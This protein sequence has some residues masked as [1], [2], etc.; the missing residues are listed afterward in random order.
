M[1]RIIGSSKD[2]HMSLSAQTV[3][4]ILPQRYP[5]QLLDCYKA[6]Y[7]D[8]GRAIGIKQITMTDPVLYGHFPGFPI[9]PGVL[10]IEAMAQNAGGL[11][12]LQDLYRRVG[13]YEALL[14]II[15]TENGLEEN[16]ERKMLILVDSR[17]K[18]MRPAYPG[19][20]IELEAQ[21]QMQRDNMIV[22]KVAALVEGVESARGQLTLADMPQEM[23]AI[24]PVANVQTAMGT[25]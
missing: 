3:H 5:L 25:K 17:V 9:Y 19:Q 10:L 16:Q 12:A 18:H 1:D 8:Q 15:N 4:R 23:Q 22:F 13:S 2:R 21:I 6:L 7:L 20:T 24:A 11:A 14:D